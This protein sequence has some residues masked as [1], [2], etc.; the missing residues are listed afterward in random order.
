V[1]WG[2]DVPLL[3]SDLGLRRGGKDKA[4]EKNEEGGEMLGEEIRTACTQ[5][6][7]GAQKLREMGIG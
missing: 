3:E 6:R 4:Q 2:R 1:G 7:K 5:R